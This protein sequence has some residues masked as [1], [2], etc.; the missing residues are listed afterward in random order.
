MS[1]LTQR[2]A[3]CIEEERK[4]SKALAF[5]I[6]NMAGE[7]SPL[8]YV[9]GHLIPTALKEMEVEDYEVSNIEGSYRLSDIVDRGILVARKI[10]AGNI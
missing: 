2:I 4:I 5:D 10:E 8:E 9:L 3:A 1:D 6:R 7:R